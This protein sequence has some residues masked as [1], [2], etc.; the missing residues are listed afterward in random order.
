ML[1]GETVPVGIVSRLESE[2]L[3]RSEAV[4]ESLNLNDAKSTLIT[5]HDFLKAA[6]T[7][8]RYQIEFLSIKCGF[9]SSSRTH[10]DE[11]GFA[12]TDEFI[13]R[14]GV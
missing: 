4:G 6:P 9:D 1:P 12:T 5:L 2:S 7:N 13:Q 14:G 10:K 8:M 3:S 11:C